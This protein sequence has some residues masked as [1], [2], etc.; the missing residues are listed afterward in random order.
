MFTM[1]SEVVGGPS[2][3]S[4]D[5]EQSVTKKLVKNDASQFQNFSVSHLTSSWHL[6]CCYY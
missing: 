3:M 6:P 4:D 1:K 2:V 5:L